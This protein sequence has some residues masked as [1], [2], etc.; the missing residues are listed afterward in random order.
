METFGNLWEHLGE[1]LGP[2]GNH[3]EVLWQLFGYFLDPFCGR[4]LETP[5]IHFWKRFGTFLDTSWETFGI[6]FD[7]FWQSCWKNCWKLLGPW[8]SLICVPSTKCVYMCVRNPPPLQTPNAFIC[9]SQN[10]FICLLPNAFIRVSPNAFICVSP[11]AF[12]RVSPNE[13]AESA[14]KLASLFYLCSLRSHVFS[15]S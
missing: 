8:T 13:P 10:A 5:R 2:L 14:T 6:T 1:P 3:L 9:V 7:L 15:Q 11:N 12:T 4:L